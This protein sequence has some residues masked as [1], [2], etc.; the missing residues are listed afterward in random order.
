MPRFVRRSGVHLALLALL[1]GGALMAGEVYGQSDAWTVIACDSTGV[2]A[3]EGPELEFFRGMVDDPFFF[4]VPAEIRFRGDSGSYR[5][6]SLTVSLDLLDR[7][8]PST[9][10]TPPTLEGGSTYG[11]SATLRDG[12]LFSSAIVATE[13]GDVQIAGRASTRIDEGTGYTVIGF[14]AAEFPAGIDLVRMIVIIDDTLCAVWGDPN[15]DG[16]YVPAE[17]LHPELPG[18]FDDIESAYR[19]NAA[20]RTCL[21]LPDSVTLTPTGQETFDIVYEGLNFA[22]QI[23]SSGG[24]SDDI[25]GNYRNAGWSLESPREIVSPYRSWQGFDLASGDRPLGSL[26]VSDNGSSTNPAVF[27]V[28]IISP[29]ALSAEQLAVAHELLEL[30]AAGF[31][32]VFEAF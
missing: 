16:G 1:L 13:Q 29:G 30:L 2:V 5:P 11:T 18:R 8:G 23:S 31:N 17:T 6:E 21:V 26:A 7:S 4:D 3:D 22:G 24:R 14:P 15:V 28:T 9:D 10:A 19:C 27:A 20:L 32:S 25:L 12:G